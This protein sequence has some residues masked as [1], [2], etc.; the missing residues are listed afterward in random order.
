[1][2]DT[3][4]QY[5]EMLER[6]LV[7]YDLAKV[8]VHAESG[9]NLVYTKKGFQP[10]KFGELSM[11][12]CVKCFDHTPTPDEFKKFSAHAMSSASRHRTGMPLGF[13]AMLLTYPLAVVPQISNELALETRNYCAKHFGA[14]EFPSVLDLSTKDLYFY[15]TTPFWGWAYYANYRKE[16]YQMFS[17]KAWEKKV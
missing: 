7:Y 4:K 17:P 8:N 11:Y 10:T 3:A 2:T 6:W 9:L 1:M 14:A 13:G 5:L 16:V 15:P 12:V